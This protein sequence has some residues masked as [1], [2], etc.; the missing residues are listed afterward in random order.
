ME[1][2]AQV[3]DAISLY[4]GRRFR[5]RVRRI[6]RGARAIDG[7]AVALAEYEGTEIREASA[8][9]RELTDVYAK[10]EPAFIRELVEEE[11]NAGTKYPSDPARAMVSLFEARRLSSREATALIVAAVLGGL[12]GA[13]IAAGLGPGGNT[14]V[15]E[16]TIVPR[17]VT[18]RGV[19]SA[20]HQ[21]SSPS[22]KSRAPGSR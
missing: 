1:L 15:R 12:I 8:L 16:T 22:S 18:A 14:T 17:V 2:D 9:Q 13:L 3:F 5:D 10:D 19:T 21:A 7:A 11:I 20:T 6:F 4:R